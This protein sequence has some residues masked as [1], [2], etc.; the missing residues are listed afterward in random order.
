M[1]KKITFSIGSI[2]AFYYL[3]NYCFSK[4]S[5][6]QSIDCEPTSN[7]QSDILKSNTQ[8]IKEQSSNKLLIE[9]SLTNESKKNLQ[10]VVYKP[11]YLIPF[12][13]Y[14]EWEII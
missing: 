11:K 12:K 10:L 5:Y 6:N 2:L 9:N 14:N 13:N 8:L 4:D 1:Y 7:K 3:Y